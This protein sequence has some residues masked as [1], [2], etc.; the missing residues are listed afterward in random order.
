M[1]S[2]VSTFSC[3]FRVKYRWILTSSPPTVC[4]LSDEDWSSH[5]SNEAMI[6]YLNFARFRACVLV[7]IVAA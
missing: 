4:G 1:L 2:L 7:R 5:A 6:R 3:F